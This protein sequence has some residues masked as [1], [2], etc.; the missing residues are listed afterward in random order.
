MFT[1]RLV[2]GTWKREPFGQLSAFR[3]DQCL[4]LAVPILLTVF[5]FSATLIFILPTNT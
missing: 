3:Q 1:T 2:R 5:T 4:G